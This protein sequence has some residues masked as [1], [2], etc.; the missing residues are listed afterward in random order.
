MHL[1][2][3]LQ[4][5][6]LKLEKKVEALRAIWKG[7][8]E[9]KN[10]KKFN[11]ETVQYVQNMAQAGDRAAQRTD[12]LVSA[13]SSVARARRRAVS[14]RSGVAPEAEAERMAFKRVREVFMKEYSRVMRANKLQV[15]EATAGVKALVK[16][17]KEN[18]DFKR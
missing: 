16:Y 10:L 11:Q 7:S 12:A 5:W 2:L 15:E 3:Q 18:D 1:Q 6:G 8:I 17:A 14:G 9:E 4:K 13:V